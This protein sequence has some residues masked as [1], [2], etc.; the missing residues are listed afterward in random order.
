MRDSKSRLSIILFVRPQA[1]HQRVNA[2]Q[3]RVGSMKTS[4]ITSCPGF[5]FPLL[6][7]IL[8]RAASLDERQ[9]RLIRRPIIHFL[10]QSVYFGEEIAGTKPA[11]LKAPVISCD[12]LKF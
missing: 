6:L 7:I 11:F 4:D 1:C 5:D 9:E 2:D 10:Q 8:I 3:L 12:F